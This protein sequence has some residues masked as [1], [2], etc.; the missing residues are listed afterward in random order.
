MRFTPLTL[1]A[2]VAL[3][4]LWSAPVA[5]ARNTC[6]KPR[7]YKQ[8]AASGEAR[9][10]E[11]GEEAYGCHV[12]RDRLVGLGIAG[13]DYRLAGRFSSRWW[14]FCCEAS[15]PPEHTIAVSNLRTGEFTRVYDV[16]NGPDD[17]GSDGAVTASV[18]T[19]DGRIAWIACV[20]RVDDAY[21]CDKAREYRLWRADRRGARMLDETSGVTL[22]SL[23]REGSTITWRHGDEPRSAT[24]K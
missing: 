17:S 16:W 5:E 24:L 12:S 20:P 8:V 9:V 1:T 14:V 7:G 23:R 13:S 3:A 15:D 18:L 6:P 19:R 11:R 2:A 4:V 21:R 22:H 10:F